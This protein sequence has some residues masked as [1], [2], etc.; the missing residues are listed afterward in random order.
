MR[1]EVTRLTPVT[2]A[3]LPSKGPRG[4]EPQTWDGVLRPRPSNSPDQ[5]ASQHLPISKAALAPTL[6]EASQRGHRGFTDPEKH[7]HCPPQQT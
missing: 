3:G 2:A 5:K 6:G 1:V 7:I 4:P